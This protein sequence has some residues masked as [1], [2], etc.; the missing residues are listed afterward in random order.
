M[1]IQVKIRNTIPILERIYSCD[2]GYENENPVH[3]HLST[4]GFPAAHGTQQGGFSE[5][6]V[7]DDHTALEHFHLTH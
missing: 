3:D 4:V 6:R 2:A 7:D 5:R 1:S